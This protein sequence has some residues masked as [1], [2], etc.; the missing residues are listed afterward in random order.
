[1]EVSMAEDKQP[2]LPGYEKPVVTEPLAPVVSGWKK[3]RG[4]K[5]KAEQLPLPLGPG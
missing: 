4:K 3:P 5:R 2:R 1:M